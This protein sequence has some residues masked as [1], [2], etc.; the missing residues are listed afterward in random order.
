[1]SNDQKFPQSYIDKENEDTAFADYAPFR[2]GLVEQDTA[3]LSRINDIRKTLDP[4]LVDIVDGGIEAA[5]MEAE[6]AVERTAR[7]TIIR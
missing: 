3:Y 2:Y 7:S 6:A 5:V 1:M 4:I